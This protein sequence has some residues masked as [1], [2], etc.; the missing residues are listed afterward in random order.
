MFQLT[1][2]RPI[3]TYSRP[4]KKHKIGSVQRR[5]VAAREAQQ[6]VL[7]LQSAA[8]PDARDYAGDP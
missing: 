7:C 1:K 8:A 6:D 4:R 3:G 2:T 5:F